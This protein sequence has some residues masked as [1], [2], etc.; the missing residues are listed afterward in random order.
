MFSHG[1]GRDPATATTRTRKES[2]TKL[3]LMY[4]LPTVCSG[5][6]KLNHVISKH[7]QVYFVEETKR[8]INLGLSSTTTA[9]WKFVPL[10]EC[11]L[12]CQSWLTRR[13]CFSNF[14]WGEVSSPAKE[15]ILW[16][17]FGG[18]TGLRRLMTLE[19]GHQGLVL[20]LLR[21]LCW[22][23]SCVL[24]LFLLLFSLF[25]FS[26]AGLV[27]AFW[28]LLSADKGDGNLLLFALLRLRTS[29]SA[30]IHWRRAKANTQA[31]IQ[32]GE[33]KEKKTQTLNI[34]AIQSF[35]YVCIYISFLLLFSNYARIISRS[36]GFF[37][38]IFYCILYESNFALMEMQINAQ[39]E[40]N[41]F[42]A[43]QQKEKEN[44]KRH[45]TH[46][47]NYLLRVCACCCTTTIKTQKKKKLNKSKQQR[48][49]VREPPTRIEKSN[50]QI[51]FRPAIYA[52]N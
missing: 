10:I 2:N 5:W 18:C 40:E 48:S 12:Y 47:L 19:C 32:R 34:S 42:R 26:N 39:W 30:V 15:R 36:T 49:N 52:F 13:C 27:V 50:G 33:E 41:I 51:E 28:L 25:V 23:R 31:H 43:P 44:S 6:L 1:G 17:G 9:H 8:Y 38:T 16:P 22:R 4:L 46:E 14:S 11:C 29:Q 37:R 24:L 45:A 21:W 35:S 3:T 20:P 7:K